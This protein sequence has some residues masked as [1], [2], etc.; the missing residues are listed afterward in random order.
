MAEA[1]KADEARV[2]PAATEI[3]SGDFVFTREDAIQLARNWQ[4]YAN[5]K[6]CKSYVGDNVETM[7]EE[8]CLAW[9]FTVEEVRATWW[10]RRKAP[11][12]S[13]G[14]ADAGEASV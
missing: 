10:S 14:E 2:E 11:A 8:L 13:P 1:S 4:E 12:G 9:G 6:D 5:R 7:I 3:K